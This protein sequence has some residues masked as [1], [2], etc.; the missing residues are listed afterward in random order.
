MKKQII[1][2]ALLYTFLIPVTTFSQTSITYCSILAGGIATEDTYKYEDSQGT[3]E[4]STLTKTNSAAFLLDSSLTLLNNIYSCSSTYT[5]YSGDTKIVH[6]KNLEIELDTLVGII[7]YLSCVQ[8]ESVYFSTAN[9]DIV[10]R[11]GEKVTLQR[12]PYSISSN[13]DSI[14]ILIGKIGLDTIINSKTSPTM[15]IWNYSNDYHT[16]Y[17]TLMQGNKLLSNADDAYL[18]VVLLG[19]FPAPKSSV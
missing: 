11:T 4:L 6:T 17:H 19:R 15:L 13:G 10:S 2:T 14:E 9:P 18:H 1:I 12:I 16:R 3:V 5:V 8:E 7:K